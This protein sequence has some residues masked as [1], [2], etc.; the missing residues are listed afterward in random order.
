MQAFDWASKQAL[1]YAF[2]GDPVGLWY[3]AALPGREAF[4][5]RDVSHQS[6]G[7]QALGLADHTFNMLHHFAA[8]ISPSRDWC[9]YWEIDRENRPAPVDYVSDAEFWYNLPANF[10]V[11]DASYRMYL[12]TGDLRYI[13]DPVFDNFYDRTMNNYVKRWA[14]GPGS[15][16]D[17]QRWPLTLP[18]EA[19]RDHNEDSHYRRG[20]PGYNESEHGYLAGIDLLAV[21]YAAWR[22]YAAIERL[23][24]DDAASKAAADEAAA[25]KTLVNTRWWNASANSFYS[26]LDARHQLKGQDA[27]DV[28]Y[29]GVAEE[30]PKT[31]AAVQELL[32]EAQHH[33]PC[34][35]EGESHYAEI[36]YRY[37]EPKEGYAILLDLARPGHCR[38]EYP[39][40]PYSEIGAITTGVMGISIVPGLERVVET[41]PGLTPKTAWADLKDLPIGRSLV[42]MRHDGISKSQFTVLSGPAVIWRAAFP[43]V[44]R[45]L[46]VDGRQMDAHVEKRSRKDVSWVQVP[47]GAGD[48]VRVSVP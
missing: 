26:T 25:I 7:A 1:G 36:L 37:G 48:T 24:G 4:C 42:E 40:V 28:L 12:W 46:L 41:L 15:I 17:R 3:E 32:T 43:G 10:D 38:Q 29:W 30:G 35:V 20:I 11:L 33:S 21:E 5:M 39:E 19:I 18:G 45:E 14:L 2:T 27:A 8:G 16:M 23:R 31:E 34:S 6:M 9:S 47:V 22:D 44:H 13:D